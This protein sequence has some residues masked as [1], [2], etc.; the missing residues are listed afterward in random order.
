MNAK[1][2]GRGLRCLICPQMCPRVFH[3]LL[4]THPA[5]DCEVSLDLTSWQT[6]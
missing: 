5:M 1:C 4:C 2:E 3:S 6:Q